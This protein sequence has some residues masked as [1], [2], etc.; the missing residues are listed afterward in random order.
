MEKKTLKTVKMKC[1]KRKN[2]IKFF[3]STNIVFII[4]SKL[5]Y[6]VSNIVLS[7]NTDNLYTPYVIKKCLNEISNLASMHN[8]Y[9][10]SMEIHRMH[11]DWTP[12][13]EHFMNYNDTCYK[14]VVSIFEVPPGPDIT[15]LK[16]KRNLHENNSLPIVKLN[17]ICDSH[18]SYFRQKK[19]V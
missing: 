8:F 5:I 2:S 16:L 1:I 14:G 15:I 7:K 13:K 19:K 18:T 11:H 4:L 17:S 6:Q 3:Q 9:H 10:D 12:S